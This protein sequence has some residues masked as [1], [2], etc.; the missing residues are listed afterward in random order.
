[1]NQSDE[2][3]TASDNTQSVWWSRAVFAGVVIAPAIASWV[4]IRLLSGLFYE[5][6]SGVNRTIWIMQAFAVAIVVTAAVQ[7]ALWRVSRAHSSSVLTALLELPAVGAIGA[8]TV[9]ASA[10]V[11]APFIAALTVASVASTAASVPREIPTSLA[12]QD[13]V[14]VVAGIDEESDTQDSEDEPASNEGETANGQSSA[15][16][17]NADQSSADQTNEGQPNE[18][19]ATDGIGIDV[20]PASNADAPQSEATDGETTVTTT[21]TVAPRTEAQAVTTTSTPSRATTTN[22]VTPTTTVR[23]PTNALVTTTSTPSR[24]ATTNTVTPTT[25]VRRPTNALVTTTTTTTTTAPTT[26]TTTS[27]TTTTTIAPT[28]TTTA[29]KALPIQENFVLAGPEAPSSPDVVILNPNNV[30]TLAEGQQA[31]PSGFALLIEA[32]RVTLAQNLPV[33]LGGAVFD[34]LADVATT[35][36]PAGTSVCVY[37]VHTDIAPGGIENPEATIS[38]PG[39]VLGHTNGTTASLIATS[40]F[41]LSGIDYALDNNAGTGSNDLISVD[42]S[43]I[44]LDF[45]T[46]FSNRDDF[47]VFVDCG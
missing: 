14:V 1:M 29:V 30:T 36:I 3:S 25:T 13:S 45:K 42:G 10:P 38:F 26:T 28:T 40:N 32:E 34:E 23:R 24:G 46:S 43:T 9:V 12:F 20:E 21:S 7:A 35:T 44:R 33:S 47:R 15:D 17:S 41:A 18:R 27:T 37:F 22:P 11:A 39:E 4:A 6:A 8:T 31:T 16:Q 5:P 19:L 2:A